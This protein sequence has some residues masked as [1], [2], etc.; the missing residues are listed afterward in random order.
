[1]EEG[2]DLNFQKQFLSKLLFYFLVRAESFFFFFFLL[3]Q[4]GVLLSVF[5]YLFIHFIPIHADWVATLWRDTFEELLNDDNELD[6]GDQWTL[7]FNYSQTAA[8]T[9]EERKRGWKVY[10]HCAYATYVK[11]NILTK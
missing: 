5:I 8:V 10:S 4:C 3:Q 2:C 9:K 7:N 11:Y 6:Y 1:M